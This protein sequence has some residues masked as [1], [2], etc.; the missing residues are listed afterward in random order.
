MADTLTLPVLPLDDA[1]VLPTMVVPLDMSDGE[2]R[3]AIEAARAVA[4]GRPDVPGIRS[5]AQ[6]RVLLVPRLDGKYASL[7]TLGVVEQ[8]GRLPGGEPGAVV[9]GISRVRIGAGTTGPGG[10]L[11][12]EAAV[13][14]EPPASPRAHELTREYRAL[15]TTI[16]QKRGAWQ[17]IDALQQLTDPSA[18]AD[19]AGYAPYLSL[20]QKAELLNTL[21]PELRLQRLADWARDHVAE[22]D[23][24]ETI[25]NDVR[26]GMEKQ[27]R[28]FLLRQQLAAIRKEL[29]ELGG[30][31]DSEEDD[32]RAR[33]EAAG[34]PGKVAE[35]ALREVDKLERASDGAPE[36]GWIRTWLDTVLDIPWNERT[37]DS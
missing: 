17:V 31:P 11:W 9:R 13:A 15:A 1:V 32:Y 37:E 8:V 19:S 22:Q 14:E 23:V 34:L 30:R 18:L 5:A 20:E 21:D 3:A 16:L 6:P 25:R 2:V 33:V 4:D 27:Q 29:A 26:E 12:V 36:A 10:A 7:G 35:A 24:A 28:E